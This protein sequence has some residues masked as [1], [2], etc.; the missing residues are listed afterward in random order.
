MSYIGAF[1][2]KYLWL[3]LYM[4]VKKMTCTYI[5]ARAD[6]DEENIFIPFEIHSSK[7][8]GNIT[9]RNNTSCMHSLCVCVFKIDAK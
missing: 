5:I 6:K 7:L 1:N 2:V 9:L 4:V 8:I 3:L